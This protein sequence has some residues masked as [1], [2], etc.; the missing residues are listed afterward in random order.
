MT[1]SELIA[2]LLSKSEENTLITLIK[3]YLHLMDSKAFFD[4]LR[5]KADEKGMLDK[6]VYITKLHLNLSDSDASPH[7]ELA[8]RLLE[9]HKEKK[10]REQ[11]QKDRESL[12]IEFANT[13][14]DVIEENNTSGNLDV[15]FSLLTILSQVIQSQKFEELYP[16]LYHQYGIYYL[17]TSDNHMA[18]K[19]LLKA[20][21][22]KD[23]I[24]MLINLGL[25]YFKGGEYKKAIEFYTSLLQKDGLKTKDILAIKIN[26]SNSYAEMGEFQKTTS[27]LEELES[28][29]IKD[30]KQLSQIYGNL[31]RNHGHLGRWDKERK[32]LLKATRLAKQMPQ[33]DWHTILNNYINL[34]FFYQKE[35]NLKK[36][37]YYLNTFKKYALMVN[38]I[39]YQITYARVKIKLLTMQNKLL[40]AEAIIDKTFEEFSKTHTKDYEY[41]S[42]LGV[43]GLVKMHLQ[44][45]GEAKEFFA[46]LYKLSIDS[47]H[48]E[49]THISLG[50]LGVCQYF[51]IE[52]EKALKSISEC[53]EYEVDLRENISDSL[54]QFFFSSN[55]ENMYQLVLETLLVHKDYTLLFDILQ[56]VKSTAIT[57]KLK[58]I[59]PYEKFSAMLPKN[60]IYLEYYIK[61]KTA[62]CLAISQDQ[63]EPV[64]IKLDINEAELKD[65]YLRYQESLKDAR[66]MIFENPFE[67]LA[68]ISDKL[69]NPIE[70]YIDSKEI[71][72]LS[73]SS[74]LNYIPFNIL[75]YKDSF[76]IEHIAITYTLHSSLIFGS[77]SYKSASIISSLKDSDKME[78]QTNFKKE[79]KKV[80]KILKKHYHTTSNI[81]KENSLKLII[82]NS[83]EILHL[84][85][86]GSFEQNPLQ[87]GFY[88]KKDGKDI[89]INLEELFTQ[90][91]LNAKFIF[92]S[93]CDNGKIHTLKGEESL[94][95]ISFL[96][97]LGTKTAILGVWE[98][99]SSDTTINIVEDFYKYW[100]EDK[101][102]KTI[103]LQ[104]AMVKNKIGVNP[105]DWAGYAL[106]G[107]GF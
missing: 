19:Y 10:L 45:M 86:H 5:I 34:S 50:Y 16:Y 61:G 54:D 22:K 49:F 64:Y 37:E 30:E 1:K 20:L 87:S 14:L 9:A 44:K 4:E 104:K 29:D 53:F 3:E 25:V 8:I 32:Y 98:I 100:L 68:E 58:T 56:K 52:V 23:D 79:C 102:I 26:L 38:T 35:K 71:M 78:E 36:A 60:T 24:A 89:F 76:L 47:S 42:F 96:H 31:A 103:A 11:I 101:Q 67:F 77:I 69:L 73:R 13:I 57:T 95:V 80:E 75:R 105:Y 106:Y 82:E 99:L 33:R 72:V 2:K 43:S 18:Q 90:N 7:L 55:R 40:E 85:N 59:I 6:F 84:L 74:Y 39:S 93:G 51:T 48:G 46:K 94:G 28:L 21:E 66:Y 92:M 70:K 62:F 12:S 27:I 91:Q 97:T 107:E 17:Y 41:L 83:F 63:K 88:L 81:N 15:A 65:I